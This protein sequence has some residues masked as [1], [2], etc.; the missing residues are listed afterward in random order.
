MSMLVSAQFEQK[1]SLNLSVGGFETIGK[2]YGEIDVY[3][4]P[5][6]KFGPAFNIGM[7]FQLNKKLSL[8]VEAGLMLTQNWEYSDPNGSY[9]SWTIQDTVT[10]EEI[11]SGENY[12][13]LLNYSLSLKP[14]YYLNPGNKF[15]PFLFAG[16]SFNYITAY[17]ED[18]QWAA[19]KK[20]NLLDADDTS[21][22]IPFL[23]TNIGLG[24]NPGFGIEYSPGRQFHFYF[25]TSYYFMP[26]Q[27][28]NFK[29]PEAEE[30]FHALIFQIGTRY[31]FIKTK[32]L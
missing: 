15:N 17:Y 9:F 26:L 4:M 11:E 20:L 5:N 3:Q 2:K 7:Q 18:T 12:L 1:L 28:K 13:E 31:N 21:P 27:A 32:D 16:I 14:V 6:Y 22:Y 25:S 10:E 8:L 29:Y 23:E 24:L 30:N 19:L